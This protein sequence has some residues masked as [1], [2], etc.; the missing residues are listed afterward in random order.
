MPPAPEAGLA[1]IL[2]CSRCGTAVDETR[3]TRTGYRVG[4]YVLHTGPTE[5][6]AIRHGEDEAPRTY[7]RLIEPVDVVACS[8][9]VGRPDVRRLWI[10]FGEET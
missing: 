7:R 1:P 6:V 2:C 9:C 3:H 10:A 4:Y 8:A 5:E